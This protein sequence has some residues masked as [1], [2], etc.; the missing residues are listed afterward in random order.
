MKLAMFLF[1]LPM[2]V[3]AG[4]EVIP[5]S[6]VELIVASAPQLSFL[7]KAIAWLQGVVNWPTLGVIGLAV[8]EFL[9]RVFKTKKP[10]SIAYLVRDASVKLSKLFELVA[11]GLD[12]VLPQRLK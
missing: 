5:A 12:K 11:K 1:L 10:L 9:L 4:E 6:E 2:T 3:Y 7:D 8:V